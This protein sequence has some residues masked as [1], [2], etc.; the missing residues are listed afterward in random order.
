MILKL[1]RL[2]YRTQQIGAS[3]NLG[4]YTHACTLYIS[5][6]LQIG[7]FFLLFFKEISINIIRLYGALIEHVVVGEE[8]IKR[9]HRATY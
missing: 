7:S 9:N 4:G 3:G 6:F 5:Y 1:C 2:R 8:L